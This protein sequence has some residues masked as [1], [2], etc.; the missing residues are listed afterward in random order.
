MYSVYGLICS[1]IETKRGFSVFWVFFSYHSF[2][3]RYLKLCAP[4]LFF[5]LFANLGKYGQLTAIALCNV[6]NKYKTTHLF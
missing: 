1:I 2:S 5:E 6:C 4:E 3:L